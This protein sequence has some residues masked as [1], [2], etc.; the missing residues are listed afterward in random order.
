M[1]FDMFCEPEC[2]ISKKKKVAK[3]DDDNDDDDDDDDDEDDDNDDIINDYDFDYNG[4]E[5]NYFNETKNNDGDDGR[6]RLFSYWGIY[7]WRQA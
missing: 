3:I 2:P 6:F 5:D 1:V 4:K 7:F